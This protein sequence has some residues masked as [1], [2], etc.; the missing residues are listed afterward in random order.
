MVEPVRDSS[1]R[2][3]RHGIISAHAREHLA[4]RRSNS[5]ILRVVHTGV[6]AFQDDTSIRAGYFHCPVTT[7]A[8]DHDVFDSETV[9][10]LLTQRLSACGQEPLSVQC[11]SDNGYRYWPRSF[12]HS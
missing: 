6:V 5:L 8:V 12:C 7:S 9:T 11:R 1:E 4:G 10:D 2:A 3:G